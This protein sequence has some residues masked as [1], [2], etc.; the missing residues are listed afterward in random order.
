MLV[1]LADACTDNLHS[2]LATDE[3]VRDI[4][5]DILRLNNVMT[6]FWCLSTFVET[7]ISA[8]NQRTSPRWQIGMILNGT[9]RQQ[10]KVPSF[11]L[12]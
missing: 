11:R 2:A 3:S 9:I 8:D 10:P 12:P 1:Q 4:V 6:L 5:A 7:D